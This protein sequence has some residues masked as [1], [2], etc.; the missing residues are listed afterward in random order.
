MRALDSDKY[1]IQQAGAYKVVFEEILTNDSEYINKY[2][3]RGKGNW[4]PTGQ[5]SGPQKATT[6]WMNRVQPAIVYP[7]SR[8]HESTLLSGIAFKRSRIH[9]DLFKEIR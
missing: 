9:I 4:I 6:Y 5:P 3:T 7:V 1:Q 2:L 8:I